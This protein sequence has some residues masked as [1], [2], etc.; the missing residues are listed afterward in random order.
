[1]KLS[2]VLGQGATINAKTINVI[3]LPAGEDKETVVNPGVE[4]GSDHIAKWSPPL[5]QDLDIKKDTL[6]PTPDVD[7]TVEPVVAPQDKKVEQLEFM[8][9]LIALLNR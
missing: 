4:Y 3:N 1:M 5:Q 2:D 9:K 7:T 8:K 6:G